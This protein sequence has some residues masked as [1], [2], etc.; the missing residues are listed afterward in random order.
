M[1]GMYSDWSGIENI[2]FPAEVKWRAQVKEGTWSAVGVRRLPLESRKPQP[3]TTCPHPV[4]RRQVRRRQP[5]HLSCILRTSPSNV[6]HP[7]SSPSASSVISTWTS[8]DKG[9]RNNQTS[10]CIL[11]T[12]DASATITI[13]IL[14]FFPFKRQNHDRPLVLKPPKG[15]GAWGVSVWFLSLGSSRF[16]NVH[17]DVR[18]TKR[19]P[20]AHPHNHNHNRTQS[21]SRNPQSTYPT[22]IDPV[23]SLATRALLQESDRPAARRIA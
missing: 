17:G 11:S 1:L 13:E 7:S 10:I 20:S 2:H 16:G 19:R 12:S 4:R 21:A 22:S 5:G 23:Q 15:G 3:T 9:S 6:S 14:R 8:I 18:R